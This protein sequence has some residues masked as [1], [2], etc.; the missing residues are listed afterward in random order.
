[1]WVDKDIRKCEFNLSGCMGTSMGLSN[2]HRHKRRKYKL[3]EATEE[4]MVR[5]LSV[6]KQVMRGCPRCDQK[7]EADRD[8]LEEKFQEKRGPDNLQDLQD[9]IRA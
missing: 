2:C 9:E 8:L 6:F 4:D 5:I 7:S 3:W 1:M